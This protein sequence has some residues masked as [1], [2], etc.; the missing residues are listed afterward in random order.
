MKRSP[1]AQRAA[2]SEKALDAAR[3]ADLYSVM[4]L[5]T[6]TKES[7][8]LA[9]LV[10][11]VTGVDLENL[12][13]YATEP[14]AVMLDKSHPE[15]VARLWRAQALRVVGAGKSK[16]YDIAVGNLERARRCRLREG[17]AEETE[18]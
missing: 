17:C 1:K 5:F 8:R 15:L 4:D 7:E 11:G 16:Y 6:E 18:V 13:H 3:G 2:W 14:A 10:R 9:E 12:S